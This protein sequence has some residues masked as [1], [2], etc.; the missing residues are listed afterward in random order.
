MFSQSTHVILNKTK[1]NQ[2]ST[3]TWPDELLSTNLKL[4]LWLWPVKNLKGTSNAEWLD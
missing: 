2:K 4:I 3:H 1:T